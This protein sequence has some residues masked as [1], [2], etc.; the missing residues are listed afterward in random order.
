MK[1]AEATEAFIDGSGIAITSRL[2][3][4]GT[5]TFFIRDP[6]CDVLELVGPGPTVAELIADHVHPS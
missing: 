3:F 4:K 1:D 5:K 6:D 2:E